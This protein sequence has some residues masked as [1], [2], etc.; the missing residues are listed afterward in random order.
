MNVNEINFKPSVSRL[1]IPEFALIERRKSRQTPFT[2]A[3]VPLRGPEYAV[4]SPTFLSTTLIRK[5]T[6]CVGVPTSLTNDAVSFK[7]WGRHVECI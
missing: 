1:D 3:C 6:A 4:L 5:P 7:E 2:K